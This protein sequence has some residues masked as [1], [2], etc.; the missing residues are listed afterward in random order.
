MKEIVLLIITIHRN[1]YINKVKRLNKNLKKIMKLN[2]NSMLNYGKNRLIFLNKKS[3]NI[4]TNSY[5]LNKNFV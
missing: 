2:M 1:S 3:I 5:K 4:I